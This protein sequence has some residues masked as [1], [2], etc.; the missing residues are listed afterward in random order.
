MSSD[1]DNDRAAD[2]GGDAPDT[3]D[4][5]TV[6]RHRITIRGRE[7][8]YTVTC[9]TLV[10][11]E[12]SEKKGEQAGEA[13]GEKPKAEIF[14][15][16][17]TRDDVSEVADRPITFSFNGGPGSS[18]VWMHLGMLGPK[19]VLLDDLGFPLPPPYRLVEN[20]YSLLD[21]SDLV[22]IDPVATG[23]SR[24]VKGEKA[25]DF[26]SLKRDVASVGDFIRLYTTRYQRWSSPKF[27]IGE[28]Y[29]TTRAAA[30]SGYLQE[31]HGMYLSGLMLISVVLNFQTIRFA[32]GNDLPPV[33][34]LPTYA[35][36]AH[37]HQRL[38]SDLQSRTLRDL[39]D[40]VE[41]FALERYGP[42]LSKGASL[43]ADERAELIRELARYTGVS[44]DY[45]DRTDLRIDIMRFVK[46][47]LRD[48]KRTVGRIDSRYTGIDRDAAGETFEYDPSLA[49]THGPY[50]ATFNDYVRRELEFELDLPYKLLAPLYANWQWETDNR[51]VDVAETLRQAM[52]IN[53]ALKVHIANGYYDL[54]TPHF[55]TEYTINHLSL[56]PDLQGN[57]SSS[58]YEAGHMMYVH[59]ES[60]EKL[61]GELERFI[62][63]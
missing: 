15:V 37:Y 41:T 58:Y 17:Y 43:P 24:A 1:A 19:R 62:G 3:Q 47:L 36:T 30:L 59:L 18:S 22:F 29:G 21:A 56:D 7:I 13:E 40:E 5:L 46:E 31:T 55:A 25:K 6:T 8:A 44:E 50:A 11:K 35:A 38:P 26:H 2:A 52:S 9:G 63:G 54:A 27:L 45:L 51:Y 12:E 20:G 60:L 14:F 48:Q 23:Y 10:F 33:L 61:K 16:A 34:Y 32:T 39:L 4:N 49:A 53:P 42:A 28:S 57:I